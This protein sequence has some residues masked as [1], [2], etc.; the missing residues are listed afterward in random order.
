METKVLNMHQE[1]GKWD[2]DEKKKNSNS[3]LFTH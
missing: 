3:F 2:I 1:L